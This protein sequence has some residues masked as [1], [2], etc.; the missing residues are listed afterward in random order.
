MLG[1]VAGGWPQLSVPTMHW[2]EIRQLLPL[3]LTMALVGFAQT[4]SIGKSL[5]NKFG[6]DIDANRELTAL[7]LQISRRA[8]RTAT[9]CPAVSRA[10]R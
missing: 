7:G 6:Y 8:C 5:G 9:R 3:A 4:I 2:A 1:P 10:R